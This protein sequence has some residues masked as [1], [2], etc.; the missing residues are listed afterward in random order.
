MLLRSANDPLCGDTR[1]YEVFAL[2]EQ[3][4]TENT[5]GLA[6]APC[7]C[8]RGLFLPSSRVSVYTFDSRKNFDWVAKK[9]APGLL[10]RVRLP[11]AA[12]SLVPF[13]SAALV[14]RPGEAGG[15]SEEGTTRRSGVINLTVTVLRGEERGK[16]AI[17]G[18]LP[19]FLWCTQ[20]T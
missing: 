18:H 20:I 12:R 15:V 17:Y 2:Q 3:V 19:V 9:G 7:I 5:H 16:K 13:F 10:A 4:Y 8:L 11:R 6:P 14:G 1:R